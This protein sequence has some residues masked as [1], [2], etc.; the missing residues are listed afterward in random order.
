MWRLTLILVLTSVIGAVAQSISG[1]TSTGATISMSGHAATFT[2][3]SVATATCYSVYRATTP[4][5][6]TGSTP[7]AACIVPTKFVDWSVKRGTTYYYTVT[8]TNSFGEG[9]MSS[10]VSGTTPSP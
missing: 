9:P 7:I 4:G 1:G 5:G 3:S 10:E 8:A 6:E 2:W